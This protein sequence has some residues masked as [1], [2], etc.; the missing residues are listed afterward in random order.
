MKATQR[1]VIKVGSN[2]VSTGGPLLIRAWMEQIVTLRRQHGVEVIWVSSGAI[3]SAVK[4]TAFDK[5]RSD[6]QVFEKQAL[7]A[8][9]Q[10]ILMDQYNLALQATGMLGAQILLTA[11][12]LRHKKRRNNFQ[13]S[14]E[15]LLSWK[16]VPILNENDAVATDEIKFG[17]NDSLSAKVAVALKAQR[18]VI[19]TDVDGLFDKD[20]RF[21]HDAHLVTHLKQVNKKILDT[22]GAVGSKHGTGGMYSKLRAAQEALKGGVETVLIKADTPAALLRIADGNYLGTTISKVKAAGR[23]ARSSR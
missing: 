18:L 9:G 4:R 8:I 6:W 12:D 22:A 2:M 15:Q 16:V 13:A 7:S 20:P 14:V 11:D 23:R 3:S 10:P 21:H 5:T 19:L 17:D 1:W